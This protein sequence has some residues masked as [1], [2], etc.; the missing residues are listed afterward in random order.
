L[1]TFFKTH[2]LSDA[3][4]QARVQSAQA[5]ITAQSGIPLCPPGQNG[6]PVSQGPGPGV[7]PSCIPQGAV[8]IHDPRFHLTS[9]KG[10]FG[11]VTAP[12]VILALLI[13]ASIIGAEWPSRTIT[14]IL[15]WE[16]RRF[17]VLSAKVLAA[18]LVGMALTLVALV[19]LGL[20][21]LPS[22][23]F[24]GTTAGTTGAGW[25]SLGGVALRSVAVT[26]I[27]AIV[28]FSIASIGRNTAAAL[29]VLFGYIVVIENVVAAFLHGLRRWLITG[30][31]IVF[32]SGDPHDFPRVSS[33]SVTACGLYLG[34]IAVG[35]YVIAAVLFQRRDVA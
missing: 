20:V 31:A 10:V 33:R 8:S 32:V 2:S 35:L 7:Q 26:A 22:A 1:I 5:Q 16:P 6:G 15:T 23:L 12:L 13:G 25:Q 29:G 11:A 17:R 18:I 21:L 28:G 4:Y 34:A 30:N 24:H 3:A 14:T 19:V 27:G 9:L